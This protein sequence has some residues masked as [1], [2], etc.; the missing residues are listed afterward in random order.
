MGGMDLSCFRRRQNAVVTVPARMGGVDL[1]SII[2]HTSL[3]PGVP[4]RMGGVDLSKNC[5]YRGYTQGRPRPH[6]WGGFKLK[7]HPC[8]DPMIL[9]PPAWAGGFK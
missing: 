5:A 1:S 9:S 7:S 3:T 4:A 6:G 8:D 2:D